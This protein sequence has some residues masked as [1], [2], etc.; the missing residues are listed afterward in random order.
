[1]VKDRRFPPVIIQYAVWVYYRF[2][3]SIRDIEYSF[4]QRTIIV[5]QRGQSLRYPHK[6]FRNIKIY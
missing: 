6:I 5:D 1:M 4:A 2:N 3:L